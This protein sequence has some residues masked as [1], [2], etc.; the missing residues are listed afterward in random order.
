VTTPSEPL[1]LEVDWT[2]PVSGS[3]TFNGSIERIS[4]SNNSVVRGAT[5]QPRR[6]TVDFA[7]V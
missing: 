6:L 1:I 7:Y 4:G 3:Q 2:A 5:S